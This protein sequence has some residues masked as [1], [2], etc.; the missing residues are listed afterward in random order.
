MGW[1]CDTERAIEFNELVSRLWALCVSEFQLK[2]TVKV[3]P[4]AANEAASKW[5]KA[6]V[7]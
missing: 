3:E 1:L 4:D 6:V 7:D 5:Q 2:F